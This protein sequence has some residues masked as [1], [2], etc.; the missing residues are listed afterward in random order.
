M[1]GVTVTGVR[2]Q[3]WITA[4]VVDKPDV[5]RPYN[6]MPV[7]PDTVVLHLMQDD[8]GRRHVLHLSV[9]GRLVDRAEGVRTARGTVWGAWPVPP[10]EDPEL[11]PAHAEDYG[12][13]DWAVEFA[14]KTCADLNGKDGT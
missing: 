14:R 7:R 13:P 11:F 3:E 9:E 8:T 5:V 2:R 10:D 6:D 12:L 4:R 1:D